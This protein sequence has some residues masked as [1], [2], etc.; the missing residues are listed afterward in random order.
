MWGSGSALYGCTFTEPLDRSSAN[1]YAVARLETII[2]C[3]VTSHC[4]STLQL[5]KFR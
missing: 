1:G 2:S 4:L 5:H 3:T